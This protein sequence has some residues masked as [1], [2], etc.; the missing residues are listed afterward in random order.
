MTQRS[1][2][3]PPVE[4]ET[5]E[6]QDTEQEK[7]AVPPTEQ[8]HKELPM[9]EDPENT[10]V[11]GGKLIEIKPTKLKYQRNRTA[12]FYH[13]LELYPL[14]DIL[15]MNEKSLGGRDGDKAVMDWLVAVT[16]D[17]QLIIENYDEMDTNTIDK[18]LAIFRRVNKITEREEKLKNVIAP[19]AK[20]KG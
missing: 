8:E 15:S 19:G 4:Q 13:M 11:I 9:V 6:I 20:E 5:R 18:L 12:A 3:T 14:T 2:E 10:I 7:V 17:P 16:D 1:K